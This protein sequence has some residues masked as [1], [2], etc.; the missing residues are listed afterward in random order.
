[1]NTAQRL[2]GACALLAGSINLAAT[3]VLRES[4][5]GLFIDPPV[6]CAV[7]SNQGLDTMAEALAPDDS[8]LMR[9]ASWRGRE[10]RY[11]VAP[12]ANTA[13]IRITALG[14]ASI[15]TSDIDIA[16]C[17]DGLSLMTAR[18]MAQASDL[19]LASYFGG[20]AD[21]ARIEAA[22]NEALA[23]LPAESLPDWRADLL[24]EAAEWHRDAGRPELA[25]ESW[26][27][28]LDLYRVVGNSRGEAA[29]LNALGLTAWR[30]GRPA[31]A[32][33][34]Y[35]QALTIRRSLGEAFA[36]AAILNNLGLMS[37]EHGDQTAALEHYQQAL[38][39]F[40]NGIEL[41][42]AIDPGEA[43][44]P[45]RQLAPE[46]DLGSALNT[47]NNLALL[48]R[49]TGQTAIAER[50]WRNYLAF[51]AYLPEAMAAAQARHNLGLLLY[52]QGRL[53]EALRLLLDART[54]FDNAGAGRWQAESRVALSLLYLELGDQDG[55]LVL[56][57]QAM[58]L[59][60]D[61]PRARNRVLRQTGR[62]ALELDRAELAVEAFQA[63][64][65]SLGGSAPLQ[66]RSALESDLARAELALGRL[67]LAGARQQR[68]LQSLEQADLPALTAAARSLLG[69]ILHRQGKT[70][71]AR[72][73]LEQALTVQQELGVIL[74]ELETLERLGRVQQQTDPVAARSNH[75]RALDLLDDPRL[76]RL[77][78]VR[79]AGFR[80]RY[81]KLYERQIALLLDADRIEA[82]WVVGERART[83]DL[84][85]LRHD[86]ARQR[87][88]PARTR[89]LDR[90]ASLLAD[91]H[92]LTASSERDA[93]EIQRIRS[94]LDRLEGDFQRPEVKIQPA[95]LEDVRAA[96]D[97]RQ[98]LLS[99]VLGESRGWVW[100]IG[101]SS[102]QV[103]AIDDV[104]GLRDD[105]EALLAQLRNPRNAIGRISALIESIQGRLPAAVHR[106]IANAEDVLIQPDRELHALPFSLLWLEDGRGGAT[107]D[108]RRILSAT[109]QAASSGTGV[110]RSLLVLADPGWNESDE[111]RS[112]Y[113]E[114][115]LLTRLMRDSALARLPGTRNEA[116]AI[117]ALDGNAIR[118][119]LRL[120]PFA[121]REFVL[122]GGLSGYTHL[123]IATH[124]LVDL[125]Y[126]ELSAL[127]LASETGAGPAF[128]RPSDIAGLDLDAALVVL[129]GCDTGYGRVFAGSA[130]F[131]LARP[132]L[133]AG[134]EQVLASLWKVDDFRTAQFM[135]RFYQHLLIDE[136]PS[137][138]A[139]TLTRD[140]MRQQRG[141]AHPYYWAGFTIKTTGL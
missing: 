124:G 62:I 129:S 64:S 65:E 66:E 7:V 103:V 38:A 31:A 109:T 52:A 49:D 39:V 136:Q 68:N 13:A 119:Q 86:R 82:A 45:A 26:S 57:E 72:A 43:A 46:G 4:P 40:Q 91:L 87:Q 83:G 90:H 37:A 28:A 135:T 116:E 99:F 94:E 23:G 41:R 89:A 140:W 134:A 48:Y 55:A 139:L 131:S 80:A 114:P 36:S 78:E 25:E 63:A 33:T 24:F 108:F 125:E 84:I 34:F 71:A 54:R 105:I 32:R 138:Q 27:S 123:H 122:G 58:A 67:D 56:A 106:A 120:G 20:Q 115:S 130:A 6:E 11:V 81:R 15:S 19:R 118:T 121:S 128:L 75:D 141:N 18:A 96:L 92:S 42:V 12:P 1:V 132:F 93:D 133:L 98:R 85:A 127:L 29:T 30:Q 77:P 17:P 22:F 69:E 113:P 2:I 97:P 137:E 21:P 70:A 111:R 16:P 112:M 110:D 14:R 5:D 76:R 95:A 74:A 3:P 35:E 53:D 61:D 60:I 104:A 101:G 47:L 88:G 51:E 117:A 79:R 10:G 107:P 102:D 8:R 9:M 73:M 126:P 100:I 59:P 44:G 50:Y